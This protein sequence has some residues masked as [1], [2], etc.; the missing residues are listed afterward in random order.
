MAGPV[1][2]LQLP[3][4]PGAHAAPLSASIDVHLGSFT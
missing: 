1:L 4:P 3:N 2:F